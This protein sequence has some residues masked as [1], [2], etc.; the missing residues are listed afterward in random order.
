LI[1]LPKEMTVDN[2][3]LTVLGLL[4]QAV[5]ETFEILTFSEVDEWKVADSTISFPETCLGAAIAILRPLPCRFTLFLDREQVREF[6]ETA[7]GPEVA[8]TADE[9]GL[10]RD[11]VG[12]LTNTIAGRFVAS[13]TTKKDR[14]ALGLPRGIEE[15][16]FIYEQTKCRTAISFVLEGIPAW[17]ALEVV[18]KK[19]P[20]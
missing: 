6:V 9:T 20:E 4:R 15:S 3:F 2:P 19:L 11:Y 1:F 14:I 18:E 7:Y 13:L 8:Q 12:E 10:L 17:C 5:Q 16:A